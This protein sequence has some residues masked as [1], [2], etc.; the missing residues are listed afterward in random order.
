MNAT[1]LLSLL[2]LGE[3]SRHQFKRDES[4]ADSIAA[5]L[6]AFANSGG[7]L[8]LLGVGDEGRVSGLDATD[9]RRLNQLLSNAAS[10]HVRPPVHPVTENVQTEQG[11]VI[12]ATVPDGL[13]KP[14]MDNQGRIWVKN[15]AD[16]RHVTAREEIQ[17]LFQRSGLIYADIV[18]V[19]GTSVADLDEKAFDNYFNRRYGQSAEFAG[20]P[21][22]QLLQNLGLADGHELNLAGLLL[23]G[24]H[25]QRYRPAFEVKA[26]AFPGIALHD[27][28]YLDSED[29]GGTLPEQYQRSF[30]FIKRNLRHLQAG[31]GFN[32][33]GRLEVPEQAIE[34]LLVNALI[35]RDYFTSASIRMMVFSDRIEIISPGHLPDNL[36][37]ETIRHGT[38]NRRNPTLTEHAVHILPYRGLGTGIPRVLHDWPDTRLM[39]DV[40]GNQFK[41]LM[42]RPHAH[43]AP[44]VTP[45]VTPKIARVVQALPI[46]LSRQELQNALRLKD[47]EHFRKSYLLPALAS[48]LVEMTHPDKPRSSKQRYRLTPAGRQWLQAHSD[49]NQDNQR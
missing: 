13:S 36:S 47:V 21:L 5:E 48:S 7:G 10:Q 11:V 31:Q 17:R 39:D 37:T 33:L 19:T 6:V 34:E 2:A 15:G 32:T 46:D 38:A 8:L 41:V 44:E 3:D 26:V 28:H 40:A 16:K 42:P 1:E 12:V 35:H 20:Q 4:N 29:I 49:D 43:G 9:V 23:F 14:Y 22:P 27:T 25:P 18:P 24:K 45:E 30:A